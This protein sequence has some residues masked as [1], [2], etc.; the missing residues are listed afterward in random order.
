MADEAQETYVVSG[1]VPFRGHAFGETFT[2]VPDPSLER[3]QAR[4]AIKPLGDGEDEFA[5]LKREELDTLASNE[6][7]EDPAS[8]PNKDAV[9]EA[10][11]AAREGATQGG[12][13]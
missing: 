8:L 5:G 6:G 1:P 7:V 9:I 2:A 4:G 11:Q 13:E 12:S 3:A 10:I